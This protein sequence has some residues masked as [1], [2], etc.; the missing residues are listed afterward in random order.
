MILEK[1]EDMS[2]NPL[3]VKDLKWMPSTLP[4]SLHPVLYVPEIR[5][6][7]LE[8]VQIRHTSFAEFLQNI[9]RSREFFVSPVLEDRK[10]KAHLLSEFI[11]IRAAHSLP[12]WWPDPN[13]AGSPQARLD[14]VLDKPPTQYELHLLYK[15]VLD[16]SEDVQ[17]TSRI[18][19]LVL[20]CGPDIDSNVISQVLKLEKEVVSVTLRRLNPVLQVPQA[21][22]RPISISH[23]SF[24]EF[25]QNAEHSEEH[26]VSPL[27]PATKIEAYLRF[28]LE[29]I[30]RANMS[31]AWW[32]GAKA[33][34]QL[35]KSARGQNIYAHLVVRHLKSPF[36]DFY[37]AKSLDAIL[38]EGPSVTTQDSHPELDHLYHHTLR[39]RIG[40]SMSQTTDDVLRILLLIILLGD[41]P[42]PVIIG[43]RLGMTAETVCSLLWSSLHDVVVLVSYWPDGMPKPIH[44]FDPTFPLFLVDRERSKELFVGEGSRIY[45]EVMR[46][47]ATQSSSEQPGGSRGTSNESL[48]TAIKK[49]TYVSYV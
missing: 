1:G 24:S 18:L 23:P 42:S 28:H 34:L 38:R 41:E 40:G 4:V 47:K 43:E 39:S 36:P 30:R 35:V 44:F 25:L 3:I 17:T 20:E 14:T 19:Q 13:N 45:E 26:H 33:V 8:H 21:P 37:P 49:Y 7:T 22:D 31:P 5:T 48:K 6:F 32:P 2:S 16:D 15:H 12:Q 46:P 10:L 29:R 27:P 11:R 9:E